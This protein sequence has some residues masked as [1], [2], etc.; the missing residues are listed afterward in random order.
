MIHPPPSTVVD[1][2]AHP[3]RAARPSV[4]M[5]SALTGLTALSI[6]MRLPAMPQLQRR[7]G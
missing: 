2:P 5:R 1:V 4:L 7:M 3:S 6:D